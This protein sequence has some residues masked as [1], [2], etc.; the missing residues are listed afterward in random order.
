M[1]WTM[2]MRFG[3]GNVRSLYRSGSLTTA[4][5]G[6]ARYKLDLVGAPE[7]MWD[8]EGAVRAEGR[9]CFSM[10]KKTKIINWEKD[11]CTPQNSIGS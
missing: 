1:Q 6:L 10:E 11:F 7:V 5:S 8:K 9:Y 3:T 2:D 4:A